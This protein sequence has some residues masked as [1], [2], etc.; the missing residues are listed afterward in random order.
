MSES[1][2][3]TVL[4][5]GAHPSDAF[6]GI[7]GTL[8]K[9][10]KRGDN[11]ILLSVTYGIHVHTERLRDKSVEEIKDIVREESTE[12]AE[13]LGVK[14]YRFLDFDDSPLVMTKETLIEVGKVIQD[15]RPDIVISVHYPFKEAQRG[16][17]HGETA[18]MIDRAPV[19]RHPDVEAPH[20]AKTIYYSTMDFI[21]G[22]NYPMPT[23]PDVFVDITDT[24]EQKIEAC[25]ATWG[26]IAEGFDPEKYAEDSRLEHRFFGRIVGVEYAEPFE[27]VRGQRVVEYLAP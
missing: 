21:A 10:A 2:K 18:R 12:A 6:P 17:D 3:L 13:I 8:A 20:R 9:H 15:T 11:V 26:S 23:P 19:W 22:L 4:G 16:H 7:G 14:D 5:I 24:M 25:I 1:Q 27:S